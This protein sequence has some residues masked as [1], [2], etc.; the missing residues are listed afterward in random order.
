MMLPGLHY[1]SGGS[2]V[3]SIPFD[4]EASGSTEKLPGKD[5]ELNLQEINPRFGIFGK[6]RNRDSAGELRKI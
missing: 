5:V 2:H 6:D 1:K 4:P 3:G